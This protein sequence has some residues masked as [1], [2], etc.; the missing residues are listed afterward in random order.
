MYGYYLNIVIGNFKIKKLKLYFF[1][2]LNSRA[3][4]TYLTDSYAKD[5]SMYPKDL[6]TR[7]MVDQRMQFDL[8]V[9]YKRTMDYYV[10]FYFFS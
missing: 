10:N 1:F 6:K 3:I 7:A 9:L 4:M 5:D 2:N 8:G